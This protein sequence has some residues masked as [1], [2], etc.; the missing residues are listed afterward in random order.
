MKKRLRERLPYWVRKFSRRLTVR[1]VQSGIHLIKDLLNIAT[2]NG[3]DLKRELNLDALQSARAETNPPWNVRDFLLLMD[4]INESGSAASDSSTR[5]I[6]SSVIIPVHNKVEYTYQCLRSLIKEIDLSET[7]I[8]VVDNGSQ[9]ETS[10]L[11]SYFK[12]TICVIS[13]PEN[14]GFGKA[15]NQGAAIASGEYLIFLNNDTIVH[16]GW[17]T[18]L[19]ETAESD[20]SIGAVGSLLLYPDGRI[21]EAGGIIWRN[22]DGAN[23]GWGENAEDGKYTFAREVDYCSA[24]SLLVR[25]KL[26]D[27]LGGFDDRY[28]PAYYEDT[29]LCFGIRSLGFKV[30]YQPMSRVVHH[31][32]VTAGT[33][34]LQGYKRYQAIN[35]VKFIEKWRDVLERDHVDYQPGLVD[36]AA[37]RRG[38]LRVIVFDNA[39]PM[40]DKDS[41][42][43]RMF[44]ILRI[45]ARLGRPV[46]VP[47]NLSPQPEYESL[48][49][50][51]G[52]EIVRRTDY[53]SL[54]KR[55]DFQVAIL[56]RAAV[57]DDV[58]ASIRKL[59]PRLKIIF[60]TVDIHFL[61]LER[62]YALTGDTRFAEEARLLRKQ[63]LSLAANSDQVWCVTSTDKEILEREVPA[64]KVKVIPNI[65]P[66]H[67]RGKAFGAREG[68]LFIGNFN[69]R[70][71][72]DALRFYINEIQHHLLKLLPGAK[73]FVVGSNMSGEVSAYA[74]ESV[75]V[76]GYVDDVSH[77]FQS[78][79]LS[80]A[81]LRYGSGMKGKIGQSLAYG[82]PVVTTT[83]GA[84]GMQLRDGEAAMLADEPKAFAEA[85]A[86]AYG[87]EK[88][89]QR[90]S[91]NGYEYVRKSLTPEKVE[92]EIILAL[93]EVGL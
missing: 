83:I 52:I 69:H 57:A 26:F 53:E 84:E 4:A 74:S 54:I 60:D 11:L 73:L 82:L 24:A 72:K 36:A 47:A 70:P 89:W 78:A 65:H 51:E 46:F 19:V 38:G 25:K 58:F 80:V 92:A 40:P 43:F 10:R 90:L 34:V 79:R 42:S 87:D 7:E 28:A 8:I 85:I 2:T 37:D 44:M 61:R 39:A 76:L 50:K 55:D 62:E 35:R 17:L 71:N 32:G 21:Q 27:E 31:Q 6:R 16:P 12:R 15:C 63:E 29:D 48:L 30:V 56:S 23:Y 59:S 22:G 5:S 77:L 75:D 3:L 9:D 18:H 64:A 49:G 66:L 33:D 91:D 93:K 45:L 68:L 81:P 14:S 67:E 1:V 41:G 20:L 88:L 13:N 86:Q